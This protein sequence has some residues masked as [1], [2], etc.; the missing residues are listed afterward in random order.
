MTLSLSP[1]LSGPKM[2][3]KLNANWK[4]GGT[5]Q[6]KKRTE[7]KNGENNETESIQTKLLQKFC[8]IFF[9]QLKIK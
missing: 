8:Q 5:S 1:L 4:K 3:A 9:F 7:V 2:W 6:K